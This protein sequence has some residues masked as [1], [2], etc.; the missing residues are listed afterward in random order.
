MKIRADLQLGG[1]SSK[2]VLVARQEEKAEHLALKLA[3]FAM[4]L[5]LNPTVDPPSTHPTLLGIDMRPDLFTLNAAGEVDVWVECGEVSINKVDKLTRRFPHARIVVIKATKAQAERLRSS[6]VD[7]IRHEQRV[8]I[9]SWPDG[10]FKEWLGAL[11]E[12]T[13][14][15]G[16]AHEKSF[17]LVVNNTAIAVDLVSF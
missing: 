6:L 8:E 12:K 10:G 3:A 16:E 5:P 9:W 17:N 15:Y 4:F 1:L 11:E 13:E 7:D 14:I 2:L